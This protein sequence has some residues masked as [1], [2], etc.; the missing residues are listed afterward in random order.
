MSEQLHQHDVAHERR[1][2]HPWRH[3]WSTHGPVLSAALLVGALVLAAATAAGDQGP[4]PR[5]GDEAA[6]APAGEIDLLTGVTD[7]EPPAVPFLRR[8][9]LVWPNQMVLDLP[10]VYDQFGLVGD[11]AYAV[12]DARGR[13]VLHVLD[14]AGVRIGRHLVE[15]GVAFDAEQ[16]DGSDVVA[17]ATPRGVIRTRWEGGRWSFGNQGGPVTVAAVMAGDSCGAG[18][19]C[20]VYVN[21]VDG[22]PPQWVSPDGTVGRV[23]RRAV[24]VNDVAADGTVAYQISSSDTGSCSGVRDAD[25]L[26]WRT[27]DHSLLRFSPDGRL[28]LATEPYRDGLGMATLAVLD[29]DTGE[30]LVQYRITG[31]FIAQAGWEDADHPLVVVSGPDGWLLLRLGTDGRR[32]LAAGPVAP[33][34]DPT[35]RLLALP[36][37]P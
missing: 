34:A 1:T 28:V 24:R 27:C 35:F 23:A 4:T 8:D 22:R 10:R 2:R 19:D 30:P 29:A 33:R 9:D 6:A 3:R 20:R 17:W 36:G 25:G 14:S 11:R 32:E 15:A 31:G 13:R 26:R 37:V 18:D 16:A 21:N 5:P 7:G 12:Y